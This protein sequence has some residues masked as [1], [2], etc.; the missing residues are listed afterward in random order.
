MTNKKPKVFI[1]GRISQRAYE[2]KDK[3][4]MRHHLKTDTEILEHVFRNIDRQT[5]SQVPSEESLP[6]SSEDDDDYFDCTKLC[7]NQRSCNRVGRNSISE[8]EETGCY[9]T[10]FPYKYKGRRQCE[11]MTFETHPSDVKSP[12]PKC[13]AKQ[14]EAEIQLPKDRIMRDP[15]A[16]WTCYTKRREKEM[17]ARVQAENR[18]GS[19]RRVDWGSSEGSPDLWALG[20]R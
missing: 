9:I 20:Q 18:W 12:F 16:C 1:G 17:K 10:R 19:T 14:K 2:N 15:D 7:R 3:Y 13:M 8:I 4:A 5:I 11:F 6:I